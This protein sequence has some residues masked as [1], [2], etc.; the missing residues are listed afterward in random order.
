MKVI[1]YVVCILAIFW[2]GGELFVNK[3]QSAY[4]RG[5]QD[6]RKSNIV[7][8]TD[9]QCASWLMQTNMKEAK[10]RICK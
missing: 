7:N 10:R 9:G 2:A 3:V 6:G 8:P 5:Y 4:W 1:W